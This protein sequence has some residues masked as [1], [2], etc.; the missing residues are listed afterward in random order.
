MTQPFRPNPS[1]T[2][3]SAAQ[4]AASS[5]R[6]AAQQADAA[7][8]SAR[9]AHGRAHASHSAYRP[10][11]SRGGGGVIGGLFRFL[12]AVAAVLF[13]G[14]VGITA[15]AG[16]DVEWAVQVSTWLEELRSG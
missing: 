6:A 11:P 15:L 3:M 7:S 16:M 5:H 8:A 2:H 10:G 13:L 1:S 9:A 4:R 14:F 12:V